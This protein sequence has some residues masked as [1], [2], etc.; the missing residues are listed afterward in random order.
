MYIR[1]KTKPRTEL[2]YSCENN[3][4]VRERT[5]HA[6]LLCAYLVESRRINGKPRQKTVY[7]A[8]IQ[9]KNIMWEAYRSQF[10]QTVQKNIEPLN[11]NAEQVAMVKAKLQERVPKSAVSALF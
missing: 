8:S 3:K 1:W 7:L 9:D 6:T 11:L 2:S 4:I 10:W 5:V